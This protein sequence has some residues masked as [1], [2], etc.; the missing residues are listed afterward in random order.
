MFVQ[1]GKTPSAFCL[2]ALP[3]RFLPKLGPLGIRLAA[4]SF[5]RSIVQ[6]QAPRAGGFVSTPPFSDFCIMTMST[7]RPSL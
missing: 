2:A 5:F 3:G 6:L 1:R 4:P 7:Q